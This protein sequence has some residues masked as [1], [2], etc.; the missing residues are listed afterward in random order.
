MN[1]DKFE[2]IVSACRS[3]FLSVIMFFLVKQA[4]AF[5]LV[6]EGNPFWFGTGVVGCICFGLVFYLGVNILISSPELKLL[7]KGMIQ[8]KS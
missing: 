8:K 7:K 5:I 3:L 1:I 6:K 2:I 4:A